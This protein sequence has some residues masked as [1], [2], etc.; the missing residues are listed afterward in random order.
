MDWIASVPANSGRALRNSGT[1]TSSSSSSSTSSSSSSRA[2]AAAQQHFWRLAQQCKREVSAFAAQNTAREAVS[3]FDWGMRSI[4][5][6]DVCE[7]EAARPA[8]LGRAYTCG[9]SNMGRY[10][11]SSSSSSSSQEPAAVEA[12]HYATSHSPWG[13]LYQLSC[14][15]VNDRLCLTFQFAEPIVERAMGAAFADS[16]VACLQAACCSSSSSSSTAASSATAVAAT[17]SSSSRGAEASLPLRKQKSTVVAAAAVSSSVAS[18]E[19]A[20]SR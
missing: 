2:A 15:T 9:V 16:M 17:A 8:T 3:V 10:P 13:S 11:Y 4:E 20:A 14:G 1:D 18:V 19:A 7:R 6:G 12:I 5:I